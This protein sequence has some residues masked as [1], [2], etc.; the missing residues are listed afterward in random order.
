MQRVAAQNALHAMWPI[1]DAAQS[2]SLTIEEQYTLRR[3]C[4]V[5]ASITIPIRDFTNSVE[6]LRLAIHSSGAFERDGKMQNA[7][8]ILEHLIQINELLIVNE[9]LIRSANL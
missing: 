6:L 7:D 9:P 2:R 5:L 4:A 8:R 1:I 3:L